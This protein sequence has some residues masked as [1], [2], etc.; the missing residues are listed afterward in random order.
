MNSWERLK[1][2]GPI[3]G[4]SAFLASLKARKNFENPSIFTYED[5]SYNVVRIFF[6]QLHGVK[7]NSIS[8]IDALELMV[9][10]NH[11]G[12]IDR[13]SDFETRLYDELCKNITDMINDPQKLCFIWLFL[14]S[15]G[16]SGRDFTENLTSEIT[17]MAWSKD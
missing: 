8:L 15:W 13:K 11:L 12:Q 16:P 9:F 6:D 14:R 1:V 17:D 2:F 7:V 5:F 3:L 10:C 4:I